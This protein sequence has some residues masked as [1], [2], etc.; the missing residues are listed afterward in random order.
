MRFALFRS[1]VMLEYQLIEEDAKIAKKEPF[2]IWQPFRSG[3]TS[4]NEV[5]ETDV[6]IFHIQ[7]IYR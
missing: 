7:G 2:L 3:Q 5:R 6:W 4:S 1:W